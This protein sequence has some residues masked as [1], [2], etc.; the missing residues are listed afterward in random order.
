M[1]FALTLPDNFDEYAWEVE[2]K[3]CFNDVF[4]DAGDGNI[5][6]SFYDP[7]RLHQ[8]IQDSLKSGIPFFGRNIVIVERVTRACIEAAVT[9]LYES[10]RLRR[11]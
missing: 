5:S 10:G 2:A 6:L 8:E 3:G 1:A 7:T 9:T 4:V 11:E